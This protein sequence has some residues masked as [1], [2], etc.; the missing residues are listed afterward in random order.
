MTPRAIAWSE[1]L[2]FRSFDAAPKFIVAALFSR[3]L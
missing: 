2:G 1:I 3:R